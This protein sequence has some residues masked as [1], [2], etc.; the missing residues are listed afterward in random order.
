MAPALIAAAGVACMLAGCASPR[1]SPFQDKLQSDLRRSMIDAARR[2]LRQADQHP[3]PVTTTRADG[4]SALGMTPEQIEE[5]RKMA[6]IESYTGVPL[7][8]PEDLTGAPAQTVHVSLERLVKSAVERNIAVQ[9]AR[10]GPAVSS[11]QV[12]AA[13]GSFDWTFFSNLSFQ[14]TNE[15]NI[16]S[17]ASQSQTYQ[18]SFGLRRTL[19]SGGRLTIQNEL[20]YFESKPT[21]ATTTNQAVFPSAVTF[22]WD[23]PLLRN[24]GTE[25]TQAEIRVLRNAERN[26]VETL[27]RDLMRVVSDTEERYWQLV[28]AHQDVLVLQR[29]LERGIR[30]RDQLIQRAPLDANAAQIA[31]A[32]SRV[33]TRQDDLLA[34]QTQLALI[35]NQIKSLV[36]DPEFSVGS[37]VLLIPADF[38]IDQPVQ[39]S[40]SESIRSALRYRPEIQSAIIGIDD[41]SIRQTV[42]RNARLPDLSLRLQSKYS[43]LNDQ[44]HETYNDVFAT[45]FASYVIGLTFEAPIGNRRAEGEYR[46]R[47]LERMQSV[48]AYQNTVRT[49]VEEVLG[50]L[51]QVQLFY[52][53]IESSR[54]NV[55]ATA[56][57]LRVLQVEKE[58]GPGYTVERL[59]LEFQQQERLAAAERGAVDA[60]VRYNTAISALF[61]AMGTTLERNNIQFVVP[62]VDDALEGARGT[63]GWAGEPA[64][65]V[66][67]DRGRVK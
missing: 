17:A 38:P 61:Q 19:V 49:T 12:L 32:M 5:L 51:L 1:H 47:V 57:A 8:L 44:I 30:V 52:K 11:A 41:A 53:R 31:D 9:F 59:N 58:I 16:G 36:N 60:L 40:L 24:F 29:L 2:E 3:Q 65:K 18:S 34:A 28:Q 63:R 15:P 67:H 42:A 33:T 39:Y 43:G 35:S 66:E 56:E 6:G 45:N 50:A 46:R 13:E 55:L 14:N 54:T 4:Q 26:A 23:Q 62:T 22:Q 10:L 27:R 25:V 64:L 21:G 48:L 20:S 37:T 7:P